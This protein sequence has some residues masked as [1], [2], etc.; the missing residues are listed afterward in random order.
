MLSPQIPACFVATPAAE[1]RVLLTAA[2]GETHLLA[3]PFAVRQVE[4][5][6]GVRVAGVS[7]LSYE[8]VEV[9][10][11]ASSWSAEAAELRGLL[12]EVRQQ[13]AAL[14]AR[15]PLRCTEAGVGGAYLRQRNSRLAES[16]R[17][18][19]ARLGGAAGELEYRLRALDYTIQPEP[20]C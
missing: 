16:H 9:R 8:P 1:G 3:L 15:G 17:G 13:L 5:V 4:L 2:H 20:S 11:P 19:L 10:W 7:Q 18:D 14:Q 6:R 12:E